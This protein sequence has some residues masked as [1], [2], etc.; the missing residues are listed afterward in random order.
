[1]VL[2]FIYF[3]SS[4]PTSPRAFTFYMTP[5]TL[6]FYLVRY[7]ISNLSIWYKC[8]IF[9]IWILL[10]NLL[11]SRMHYDPSY[12]YVISH[13]RIPLYIH[14]FIFQFFFVYFS[15]CISYSA[16]T[17]VPSQLQV[18]YVLDHK[19]FAKE[20]TKRSVAR[21]CRR[22]IKTDAKETVASI[23]KKVGASAS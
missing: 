19:R 8:N 3:F 9:G 7:Q 11:W 4:V 2:H 17:R 16:L 13:C 5:S 6:V 23:Y 10:C 20:C 21:N 1:M 22:V 12:I 14:V 15:L 18:S